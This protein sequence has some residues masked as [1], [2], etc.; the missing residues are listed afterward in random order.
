M[1]NQ[2]QETQKTYIKK[3]KQYF[4]K[5]KKPNGE[6]KNPKVRNGRLRICSDIAAFLKYYVL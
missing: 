4:D 1:H 6:I 5:S 3:K 2:N